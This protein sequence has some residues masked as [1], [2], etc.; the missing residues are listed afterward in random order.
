MNDL[1]LAQGLAEI[2]EEP[3]LTMAAVLLVVVS[4]LWMVVSRLITRE[5]KKTARREEPRTA[6]NDREIWIYPP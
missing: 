6:S 3:V 4:I 1:H 2:A 5:M